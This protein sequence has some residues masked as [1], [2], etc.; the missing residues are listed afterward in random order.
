MQIPKLAFLVFCRKHARHFSTAHAVVPIPPRPVVQAQL[1]QAH[2]LTRSVHHA[3][4]N[5]THP[6]AVI[7]SMTGD[8]HPA[9]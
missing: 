8:R 2:L 6:S 4:Q 7:G 3:R 1:L 5:E 9:R